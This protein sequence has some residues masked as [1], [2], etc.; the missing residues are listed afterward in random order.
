MN[1][2]DVK[3]EETIRAFVHGG[4]EWPNPPWKLAQNSDSFYERM[5]SDICVE[6]GLVSRNEFNA[7]G[8]GYA[9]FLDAWFY[10]DDAQFRA[11][12]PN[13]EGHA[14][15]GLFI[16][17]NQYAPLYVLGEGEKSW[18]SVSAS[19]YLPN[20][21]MVDKFESRA[22]KALSVTV[23]QKL[24]EHGMIRLRS[25]EIMQPI[26]SEIEIETNLSDGECK[27]FDALFHW[28]D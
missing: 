7:Y 11:G 3:S 28:L 12:N 21:D 8:C 2:V 1:S 13:D 20:A 16:L 4:I 27:L 10:K 15:V 19:S 18:S 23:E 6:L 17:L 9:S 24:S 5:C 22:V 25:A 14:F 26:S